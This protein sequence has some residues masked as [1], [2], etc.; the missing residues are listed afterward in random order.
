[1]AVRIKDV[2]ERAGVSVATVS[3]T[4][5]RPEIVSA[6]VQQRVRTASAELGYVRNESA[7]A[8][9]TGRS[10]T[11]GLIV[12]D[13]ANP[14]FTDVA[15]GADTVAGANEATVALCSSF[16]SVEREH[17]HLARF[18]A[19]QVQGIII[20]PLDLEDPAVRALS[21]RGTP[22]V[23]LARPVP[24][25][26]LCS[27][28]TDDETGGAL[29]A[30]HLLDRGHRRLAFAGLQFGDRYQGARAL[31]DPLGSEGV[32]LLPVESERPTLAAGRAAGDR[33]AALPARSRP[34]GVICGNDLIA[35]GVLQAMTEHG[36]RVPADVALIG[37]DD[38]SYAA[39]AAVP[40]SSVRQPSE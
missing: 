25:G 13:W 14:F 9:R 31:I 38:I 16:S 19:A 36:L 29:A 20:T 27:V 2:A 3:N 33:I 4:F 26:A 23:I 35:L 30:R 22:V 15:T 11:L 21:A 34:T 8:L 10:R 39:G 17:R 28:R 32:T 37:F 40:L 6:G 12:T 5:N 24:D 7:R 18:E 1:M